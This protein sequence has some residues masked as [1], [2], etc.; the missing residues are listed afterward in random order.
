VAAVLI[1][2]VFG[3]GGNDEVVLRETPVAIEEH[4]SVMD[5]PTI[6]PAALASM[7]AAADFE[8]GCDDNLLAGT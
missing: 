6:D 8:P 5:S 7:P 1:G 2:A 4:V 3:P